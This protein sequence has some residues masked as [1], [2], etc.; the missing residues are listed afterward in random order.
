MAV[1]AVL[2]GA[3]AAAR[4]CQRINDLRRVESTKYREGDGNI[5]SQR[6]IQGSPDQFQEAF[7]NM[8]DLLGVQDTD[9]SPESL[10]RQRTDLADLDP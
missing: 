4:F 10:D 3:A 1:A 7:D 5:R 2:R 8:I 9:S 6:A